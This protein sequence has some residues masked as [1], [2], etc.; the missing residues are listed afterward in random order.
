M[1]VIIIYHHYYYDYY[2]YYYYYYYYHSPAPMQQILIFQSL[3][4]AMIT[5]GK[6]LVLG[7]LLLA[8]SACGMSQTR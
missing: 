1:A 5:G 3:S 2:Y 7:V 6:R 4:E 8:S